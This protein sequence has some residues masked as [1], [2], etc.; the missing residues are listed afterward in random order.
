MLR[1][2]GVLEIRPSLPL[3]TAVDIGLKDLVASLNHILVLPDPMLMSVATAIL[4]TVVPSLAKTAIAP[5]V[6][7]Y[8]RL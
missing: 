4:P 7:D 2:F 6:P 5:S 3:P 1:S 8:L